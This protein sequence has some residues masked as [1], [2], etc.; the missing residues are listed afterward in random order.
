[1]GIRTDGTGGR[2]L[3]PS[4][5]RLHRLTAR[6][7]QAAG[8]GDHA[9]GGGL[10]LRVRDKSCAWVF[11]YT[12]PTGKRREMGLGPAHR[13]SVEQAGKALV[14]ARDAAHKAREQLRQ[15]VDPIDARE[16][17]REAARAAEQAQKADRDRERWTLARSGRDYHARIIETSRTPKHAAQ[18]IASLENHMPA[19][20][21]HAPID[22]IEPP[23]LLS[24]LLDVKPHE[25][26]RRH[27][28]DK[29]PET[30]QRIRQ[31]LDAIFEDAIFHKRCTSN[32]AAAIKRK[33][34]EAAGRRDRGAFRAMSYREAPAFMAALRAADGTAA[35]CLEFTVL[36]VARTSEALLAEWRE[37]DLEAKTWSV[38]AARMKAKEPHAVF[39]SERAIAIVKGMQGA[40]ERFVF[41]SPMLPGKPMSN[42]AMLV[43]LNR[44]GVRD[45]TTVHGLARATFSTW[46]NETSAARPDVIEACLAHEEGNR[47]RAA[48]NRAK[49]NDERRALLAAWADFLSREPAQVIDMHSKRGAAA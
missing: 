28:G 47:V 41:P 43:T 36:A 15:G 18:W 38:P 35:R 26:A 7:V 40:D 16:Q 45:R 42:M 2:G 20:L 46:A 10:L 32:P 37:F 9:D 17:Y 27:S 25:R 39:L 5:S 21:W 13:G 11:K 1:M 34:R 31:R 3:A 6:Q 8:D 48:Y 44:L 19:A 24:V 12:A 33:M 4:P 49:F 23:A 30:V 22:S 29:V 14:S